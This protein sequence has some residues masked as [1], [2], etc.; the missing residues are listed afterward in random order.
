MALANYTDLKAAIASRLHRTDLTTQIVDY[1]TIAEKRINRHLTLSDA[2]EE[3]T[4][5]ASIGSRSLTLPGGFVT[6]IALY[7]TSNLPRTEMIFIIPT[8][9]QY[10]SDNGPS[11]FWT[12]DSGAIS[13]DSPADSAYTYTLR[14]KAAFDIAVTTTNALLTNYP[15]TYL[16][17]ALIEA[18]LD[19]KDD[20]LLAVSERRFAQALDECG[21]TEN[22]KRALGTLRFEF[23]ATKSN[24]IRGI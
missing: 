22:R 18:A 12:M 14:Y 7:D 20:G 2:E 6:P 10:Y 16:Y 9:M 15:E 3:T 19:I 4:L 17:G 11:E 1:I 5:T 23:A 24:I 8:E 21:D 13:T